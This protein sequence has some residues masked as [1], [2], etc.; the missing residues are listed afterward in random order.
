MVYRWLGV[1][2]YHIGVAGIAHTRMY[3]NRGVVRIALIPQIEEEGWVCK[4]IIC[5]ALL[6]IPLSLNIRR[7]RLH[8]MASKIWPA[9]RSQ[10]AV[11]QK[12][13]VGAVVTLSGGLAVTYPTICLNKLA[14]GIVVIPIQLVITTQI[15]RDEGHHRSLGA[16]IRDHK[17][18]PARS[19]TPQKDAPGEPDQ[20]GQ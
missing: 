3:L 10:C 7:T 6:T 19:G 9:T 18:R 8:L 4:R 11:T 5:M 15:L 2:L 13:R 12:G 1:R 20:F 16:I 17:I 14:I